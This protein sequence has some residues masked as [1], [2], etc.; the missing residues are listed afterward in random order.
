[1]HRAEARTA[2]MAGMAA[3]WSCAR[4]KGIQTWRIFPISAI[5]TPRAASGARALIASGGAAPI[6]PSRFLP[7]RWFATATAVI[8]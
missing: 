3:M 8:C 5:G 7:G 2:A 4:R 1:M 6:R